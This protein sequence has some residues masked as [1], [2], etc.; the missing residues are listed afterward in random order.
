MTISDRRLA[1]SISSNSLGLIILPTEACNFRCVYC[2]EKFEHGKMKPILVQA[3]KKF[4]TSRI[5]DLSS[6]SISWF[7]GEPLCAL[8]IVEDVSKHINFLLKEHKTVRYFADMTTNGYLLEVPVFRR[9]GRLGISQYQISFDGPRELHDRKRV[10]TGGKGTFDRIWSNL[11]D[12]QREDSE[13]LVRVRL[14]IDQENY[15]QIFEFVKNY[16][17]NFKKDS[18]FRLFFRPLSCLGGENDRNLKVFNK[19]DAK[20]KVD[21]LKEYMQNNGIA[22]DVV[23]GS[24]GPKPICYAA[25][26]NSF[27][28]RSDGAINK[29]TVAFESDFNRVG[30]L[31]ENGALTLYR[32]K[33]LRWG[34]GLESENYDELFCPLQNI[35]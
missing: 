15:P 24:Q 19:V 33:F 9:L 11:L 35:A 5:I 16:E 10:L 8:D 26:L 32:E 22:Y 7:G 17:V 13:F 23:D 1:A 14:H 30:E 6:L 12:I 20:V 3:L 31:N 4:I 34:R 2:Y 18:R 21:E 28:I 25:Q 27:V 29:C